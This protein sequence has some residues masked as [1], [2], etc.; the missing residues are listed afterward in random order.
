MFTLTDVV[1]TKVIIEMV[2]DLAYKASYDDINSPDYKDFVKNFT[3]Q[4]SKIAGIVNMYGTLIDISISSKD[5]VTG[6]ILRYFV[7]I[8]IIGL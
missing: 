3:E 6:G 5:K 4:V 2:V 1:N 8:I 7:F